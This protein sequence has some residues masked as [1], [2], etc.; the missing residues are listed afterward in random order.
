MPGEGFEYNVFDLN[1]AVECATA[2]SDFSGL[3]C[4][5]SDAAG[6]IIYESGAGCASCSACAA[7]GFSPE[8]C[9]RVHAYGMTEAERFGGKYIYFCPLGL[10]CFVSPIMGTIE[11]AAKI[12]VGPFFMTDRDDYVEFDLRQRLKLKDDAIK[13]VL[14]E[15]QSLPCIPSEKVNSLSI[16]LF[17]AVGF[18]NN[19]SAAN[20]MLKIQN[21]DT[22]QGNITEYIMELKTG[23][24]P[25]YPYKTEKALIASIADFDKAKSQTLLNELLGYILFSSGGNI[26]TI[27]SR[28]FELLV[29]MSRSAIDAGAST[30]QTFHINHMFF[31]RTAAMSDI[32]ELCS[33]LSEVMN[34]YIDSIFEFVDVKNVEVIQKAV[35]YIRKNYTR[36]LMIEEVAKEICLSPTYF[37]KIFKQEIGCGFNAYLN[38]LRIEK[39]TQ[40]LLQSDLQLVDIA[41]AIGFE[42]QSYFTKVFKRLTGISPNQFKKSGAN[43]IIR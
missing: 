22:I 12:T 18:V 8:T 36:K 7:V 16:L 13:R 38:R 33:L 19:V 5:L 32:N 42:D 37:S 34:S 27:K 1:L 15:T 20:R 10:T 30:V 35:H 39:S 31:C 9:I 43:V 3:G 17:M 4:T 24:T 25:E 2:Y 41:H 6:K 21:S 26:E 14:D 29:I 23:E 40:L 28:V 11:S